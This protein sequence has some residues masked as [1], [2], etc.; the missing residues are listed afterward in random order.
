VVIYGLV[1]LIL[2]PV[3]GRSLKL[4]LGT[5]V[6]LLYQ[7]L[8]GPIPSL[9]RATLMLT[10]GSAALLLD[11]DGE[12]LNLLCLAGTIM[13]FA[14]PSQAWSPSFQLSFLALAG[15]LL[16][17]PLVSRPLEGRVP[18]A[19]LEPFAASAGAQLATLPVVVASFGVYYPVGLLAS[20]VLV[21]LTTLILWLG[22]AWLLLCPF[23]GDLLGGAA[24]RL[25]GALY[26]LV[27]RSAS[28]FSR[29]PGIVVGE[30]A[31]RWVGVLCA[32]AVIALC[33]AVPR[34]MVCRSRPRRSAGGVRGAT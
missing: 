30:G 20:L 9:L 10:A 19:I 11:R 5:A 16:L 1:S 17:G 6:L 33:F 23:L 14:D 22:L 21:P 13:L 12:P 3:P 2:R 32:A 7:F 29:M 27:C 34:R 8:A 18:A 25:F 26:D 15:I 31:T 4:I 28:A 24:P